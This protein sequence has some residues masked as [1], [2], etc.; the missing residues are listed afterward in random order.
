MIVADSGSL[1]KITKGNFLADVYPGLIT[2]G[3][4]IAYVSPGP[5]T[6][7]LYCNG[8]EVSQTS[9]QTL[10]NALG[11]VDKYGTGTTVTAGFFKVPN[12]TTATLSGT[13]GH[14]IYYHIKT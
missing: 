7:W 6:G 1:S 14:P 5:Y 9:Y 12:L 4:V 2:T 11:G 10:W 8:Q 13:N 3:M